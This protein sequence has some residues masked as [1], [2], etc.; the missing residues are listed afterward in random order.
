[1][2]GCPQINASQLSVASAE[3]RSD[4]SGLAVTNGVL[5][6]KVF[7]G[8]TGNLLENL[9][10]H[11]RFPNQPNL[12]EYVS[13]LETPVDVGNSYGVQLKGYVEPPVS[14]DYVFY[15]CSDD[16]GALFLSTDADPANKG[17]IASEP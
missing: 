11:A 13:L 9:I 7:F 3:T 10:N 12:V 8:I 15:L 14:G 16:Q 2:G 5:T 6:R 4:P 17:L 1:L